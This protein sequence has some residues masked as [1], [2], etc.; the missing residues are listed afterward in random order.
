M[1]FMHQSKLKLNLDVQV[2]LKAIH[3]TYEYIHA[4]GILRISGDF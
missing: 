1:L 2:P 4:W 3:Q